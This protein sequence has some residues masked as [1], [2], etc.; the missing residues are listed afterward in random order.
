MELVGT[1]LRRSLSNLVPRARRK[2][3]TCD[4]LKEEQ[5]VLGPLFALFLHELLVS[6]AEGTIAPKDWNNEACK[7]SFGSPLKPAAGRN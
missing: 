6:N 3:R 2:S 4:R 7:R 1:G 5:S